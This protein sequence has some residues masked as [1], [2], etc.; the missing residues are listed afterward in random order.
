MNNNKLT[1]IKRL[2]NISHLLS[3][4]FKRNETLPPFDSCLV[5]SNY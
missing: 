1:S 5:Q 3:R 4:V 2:F